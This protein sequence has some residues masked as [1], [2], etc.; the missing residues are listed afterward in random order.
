MW[1]RTSG[2]ASAVA[3]SDTSLLVCSRESLHQE[4]L[5]QCHRFNPVRKDRL[6]DPS[7]QNS[8]HVAYPA[9]ASRSRKPPG[10][11]GFGGCHLFWSLFWSCLYP[12]LCPFYA[13]DVQQG[14]CP[15]PIS[16]VMGTIAVT[17][18]FNPK[19]YRSRPIRSGLSPEVG[20]RRQS[21]T[22]PI[23][24]ARIFVTV[25]GM[26]LAPNASEGG[27]TTTNR[28]MAHPRLRFGASFMGVRIGP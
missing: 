23:G 28:G 16:P 1:R 9:P 17:S 15:R 5:A 8:V 18:D 25:H 6:S 22:A 12:S 3:M 10:F 7:R 13:S 2:S 11:P 19:A 27:T 24:P 4:L 20:V 21:L 26:T 14:E